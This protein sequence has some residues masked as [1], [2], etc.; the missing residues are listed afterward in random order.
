[1]VLSAE[2]FAANITRVGPLIRVCPLVDE[3]VVTLGEVT[4]AIFTDELLLW[5]RG[6]ARASEQPRVISWVQRGG[7]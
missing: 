4:V 2:S 1:M 5:P 7:E 3:E 6:A